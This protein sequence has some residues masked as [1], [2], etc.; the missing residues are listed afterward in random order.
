MDRVV[1]V[2]MTQS[3]DLTR[4][5]MRSGPVEDKWV[6]RDKIRKNDKFYSRLLQ[7][8]NYKQKG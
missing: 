2:Y 6:R 4:M 3:M 8:M 1:E 7:Q 5:D